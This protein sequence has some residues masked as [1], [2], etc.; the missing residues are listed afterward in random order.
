L[1]IA[2]GLAGYLLG[3][4]SLWPVNRRLHAGL[5]SA[6]RSLRHDRLT[7]LRNRDG[8]TADHHDLARDGRTL[9]TLLADV[10][11]FK[12]INDTY[13]HQI[14]D[15]LLITVAARIAKLA[16]LYHGSAARLGGDEFAVLIPA[17][18]H[19]H[20]RVAEAFAAVIRQPIAT[21]ATTL[22]VTVSIGYTNMPGLAASLHAAD[23]AMYH[24]KRS[25]TGQ[26]TGYRPGMTVLG[27]P[28]HQRRSL[29]GRGV[30]E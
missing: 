17:A 4:L 20:A 14:G 30:T 18:S 25:R 22:A 16:S 26:P 21:T 15:E 29:R 5:E 8:L 3:M 24:A 9:I 19:D 6:E 28:A 11:G 27:R 10:D 2:I 1:V 7:G 12:T 13:G 23:I